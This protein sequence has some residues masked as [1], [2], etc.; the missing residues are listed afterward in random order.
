MKKI[1]YIVS[2]LHRTGP[3]NVLAGIVKNLNKNKFKPI[4]IT[5]SPELDYQNSWWKELEQSGIELYSLNLSRLKSLFIGC[6]KVKQLVDK[7][8]PDLVHCH[9]FRSTVMAAKTLKKY[10][11]IVTIHCDYEV[12]F[13]M[14]YGKIQGKLISYFYNRSLQ[15]FNKRIACSKML[16]D[17]LNTKYSSMHFDFVDNGVDTEKFCPYKDKIALRKKLNFPVDKKIIIW[18]GSFIPRKDPVTMVQAI[19]QIPQDKYFFIFCGNGSLSGICREELKNRKDVLFTDYITNI[20]EYYQASDIYISTSLSEGLPLAVLEAMS[21]GLPC[22]LSDIAQ[23][24][25]ILKEQDSITFLYKF[26]AQSLVKQI[27]NIAQKY[28]SEF[29]YFVRELVLNKFSSLYMANKYRD[30]YD[31]I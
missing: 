8:K 10:K 30:F 3:T 24:R 2:T 28:S 7:I 21:C 17:L 15:K 14:A 1:V 16:A 26:D 25:Y 11:K 9:C 29:S 31:K 4:I 6:K 23:H 27:E 12:D 20:E 5:L 19:K 13:K 18:A 22:V